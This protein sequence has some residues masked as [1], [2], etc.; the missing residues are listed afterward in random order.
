M[1]LIQD[2][3][4]GV[5]RA[6]LGAPYA[7]LLLLACVPGVSRAQEQTQGSEA[8]GGPLQ[9]V[10]V[11]ATRRA[12]SLSRVPISVTALT[13]EGLD[14]RGV[15]DFSEVARFTPGVNFDNSGTNNIS[16]RGISGTGGAGTTGIYLDDTPIQ[17]R[18]LAFNPD[19]ALPKSF[20]IDRVE[21][22]R[23][24]QGTLFGAGSEGGT[25]RYITTQPSLTKTSI[26]SRAEFSSTQGGDPS[27]EA[28]VA[29]GGP[30]VQDKFGARLS[31]WYRKDG[32]WIDRIDPV[33]LATVDEKANHDETVL[34]RLAG[35]W[36]PSEH[37]SITPSI[38]Y[39]DRARN[40]IS[41]Y[42]P[43]YSDPGAHRFV[44]A[45]PSRRSSPDKFY[46]PSLKIEGDIGSAR[47]ISNT[48]YF[49]RQNQTGYEG[50]LYNL[51]FY[52]AFVFLPP[53]PLIDGNG[54]HLPPGATNY[55]SPSSIDNGQQNI[56]QEIRLQS[57]DP[58]ARLLWTTGVFF[59]ENRQSYLEQIHDPLLNELSLA[60]TGAPYTDFFVDAN[61]N[62]VTFDPRFPDDSYFL[63][64]N[65]K[66]EQYAAFGELTYGLTERLK[67]TVG[68]RFSR[69]KFSFDTLT[70]GPQLFDVPRT[71][72]GNNKENSFTPKVSFQFQADPGDMFYATYA[73][74]F[75]PGGANNPVPFAACSGDFM[76]FN[77]S[78]AP[79]TYSSD[80]VNSY[81]VGAKNNFNNRV[82]L[83][84][85]IYYIKWNNIQ[86]TVVPPVCQISFIANLGQ[87]AAK[88][89]D[90][91]ADVAVT[92]KL[93]LELAAGY[94]EARYS[95]DSKF[96]AL[97]QIPVVAD[98]DAIVGASSE[99]G[100][101]QPTAPYTVSAGLQYRFSAFSHE[102]FVRADGEYQGR[103][104]WATAGQDPNSLQFD[105]ANFVLDATTFVSLRGGMSFGSWSVAAFVDNL[106][107]THKL[108]D[109][110]FTINDGLG[111]SRLRRDFTFRP[112]TFG[113][114]A[115]FRQ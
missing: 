106:T 8:T 42:W 29:V 51:G 3:R 52:Q 19:E 7:A 110:N 12:E 32:G 82:K 84:S 38:Y 108:T 85:S 60:L 105:A 30:L 103:A 97:E 67:A 13:Q 9:E 22:L 80:T 78:G 16:I 10:I 74:G 89:V 70:G 79:E 69:T 47:L 98:G 75:R 92:E 33:T 64:T 41:T 88:G 28:G 45:D 26:Y 46:L 93:S 113:I 20:D 40:D 71:G 76:A 95:R 61:G 99:T 94:T 50:T 31:V 11:T 57:T 66:D 114:T 91:Q 18:A 15:K 77:I 27:Y 17:M 90:F 83:A 44:S 62:P 87:A 112:R 63:K 104:K 100:G 1:R 59:S 54:V 23:G 2:G 21:V 72:S 56:T 6:L 65:A 4:S 43:L 25:V 37:W 49:H 53:T 109:Y 101:G 102:A 55:R 58:N 35:L 5:T 107:D 115:I 86:Q 111:D 34:V 14:D 96:N 24:P 68:A 81:E 73:K 48:S 36:A 39:Q